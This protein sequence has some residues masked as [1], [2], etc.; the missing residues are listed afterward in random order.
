[1]SDHSM[2][3]LRDAFLDELTKIKSAGELQGHVRAGRRP[4]HVDTLLERE[5]E[6]D[7]KPSDVV[8]ISAP[9]TPA[10]KTL[11]LLGAGAVG[12]HVIR[13]ANEDR[14]IGRMVRKQQQ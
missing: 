12:G 4:F 1:M 9:M 5:A 13:Q 14:K 8:K 2:A 11:A 10:K 6:S 3:A 7:A